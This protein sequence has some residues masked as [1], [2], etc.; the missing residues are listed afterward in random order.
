MLT[1][2][3]LLRLET[4]LEA[5]PLLLGGATSETIMARPVPGRWSAHEN[6]AHLAGIISSSW[7]GFNESS[8]RAPRD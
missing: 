3:T 1:K 8:T 2:S 7:N 6:L 4:Q 5:I